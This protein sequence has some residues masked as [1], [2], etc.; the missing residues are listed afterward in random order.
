[1]EELIEVIHQANQRDFW[2]YT[3]IVAPFLLSVVAIAISIYSVKKQ[4]NLSLFEKRYR[5]SYILGF[6]VN[7]ANEVVKNELRD[8]K[9][10][11]HFLQNSYLEIDSKDDLASKNHEK[12]LVFYYKLRF[13]IV[14]INSLYPGNKL[15]DVNKFLESFFEYI[16][17]VFT[18]KDTKLEK[19]NLKAHLKLLERKKIFQKLDKPLKI[20]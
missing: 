7:V 6:L 1:M 12:T 13:E 8:D 3:A 20:W 9:E 11:L 10:L 19:E 17:N 18:D 2:D 4:N 5:M 16:S 14:G 15:K